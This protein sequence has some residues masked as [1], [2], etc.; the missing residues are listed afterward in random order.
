MEIDYKYILYKVIDKKIAEITLNRPEKRNALNADLVKELTSAFKKAENDPQI[1]VILL[2]GEGKS[3]CAGAD[4]K[5]LEQLTKNTFEENLADSNNLKD[6][7][8]QIYTSKKIT[9][10]QIEGHAIAGGAG[11]VTVVDFAFSVPEANFGFTE[12]KLGF[13][14]ALVSVFLL[15]KIGEA[16]TKE[17]VLT[18]NLISA[19]ATKACGLIYQVQS[20]EK[21]GNAVLAFI[22]EHVF[23]TSFNSVTLTKELL[24]LQRANLLEDLNK[25]SYMNAKMRETEDFKKGVAAFLNKQTPNWNL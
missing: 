11:L 1:R 7:F 21:I 22:E 19:E 25:A 3:F 2:K 10:A 15:R 14:P 18:G 16:K 12:V 23:N 13:I 24:N 5:Y 9:V 8:Y 20:A 6:L 17:L 4:L